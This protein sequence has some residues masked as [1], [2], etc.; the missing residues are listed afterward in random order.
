MATKK[1]RRVRT[2]PVPGT[3]PN[4]Q[5]GSSTPI[6]AGEDSDS[7]W[8]GAGPVTGNQGSGPNDDRLKADKPPHY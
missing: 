5:Q 3:D 8:G 7:A 2:P 1:H 4:P 6:V